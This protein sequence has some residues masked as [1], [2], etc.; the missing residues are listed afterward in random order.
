MNLK[1]TA[2]VFN[3]KGFHA[4]RNRKADRLIRAL[5]VSDGKVRRERV[6]MPLDTL[7]RGLKGLEVDTQVNAPILQ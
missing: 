2:A 6:K 4:R 7:Y 3:P 5:G 1:Y